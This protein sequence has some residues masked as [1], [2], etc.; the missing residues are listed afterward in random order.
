MIASPAMRT[1]ALT[2]SEAAGAPRIT[3][4]V[5]PVRAVLTTV[6]GG[7]GDVVVFFAAVVFNLKSGTSGGLLPA[8]NAAQNP[9]PKNP[10]DHTSA[11]AAMT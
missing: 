11:S 10:N 8:L 4:V 2:E 9:T 3:L 7:G 6:D 1:L 5:S